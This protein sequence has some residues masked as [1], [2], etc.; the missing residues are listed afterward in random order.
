MK[1]TYTNQSPTDGIFKRATSIL[2]DSGLTSIGSASP[3]NQNQ[4]HDLKVASRNLVS[5][6]QNHDQSKSLKHRKNTFEDI[7]AHMEI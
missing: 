7:P 2:R 5:K 1:Q 3:F 6:T 4:L